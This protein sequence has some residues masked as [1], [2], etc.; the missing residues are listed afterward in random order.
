[1]LLSGSFSSGVSLKGAAAAVYCGI[2]EMGIT[3]WLWLRAL[4][5]ASTSDKISNLVYFAPFH[6]TDTAAFHN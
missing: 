4:Q 6:L 3:F 1:M 5:L 2:F